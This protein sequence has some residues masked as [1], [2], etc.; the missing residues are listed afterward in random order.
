[1][2]DLHSQELG[3]GAGT[4]LQQPSCAAGGLL[5]LRPLSGGEGWRT[6]AARCDD[7]GYSGASLDRRALRRLLSDIWIGR[8]DIVVVYK[9]DRLT[10]S[11]ADFARIIEALDKA[12]VAFVSITQAFNTTASMG[13]LTLNVLL[14]FARQVRPGARLW[15]RSG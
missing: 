7:G 13:R 3:R 15:L 12:N 4:V 2:R 11:L 14:S 1:M 8:V 6:L 5:G 10:S 9:V